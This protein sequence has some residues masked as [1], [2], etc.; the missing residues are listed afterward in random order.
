[1]QEKL[2][3]E[4]T[5]I[6]D[7]ECKVTAYP[8]PDIKWFFASDLENFVEITDK[9]TKTT[10][11]VD[12]YSLEVTSKLAFGGNGISRFNSGSYNCRAMNREATIDNYINVT[13]ECKY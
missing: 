6:N 2:V 1:M 3:V 7:L 8:V 4:E 12:S 11:L 10:K 5:K 9:A 13:V